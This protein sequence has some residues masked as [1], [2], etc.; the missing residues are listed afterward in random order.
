MADTS[1]YW[2]IAHPDYQSGDDLLCRSQLAQEGRAPEWAWDE[3]DQ[4]FDGDVVCLFPDTA[5]GR[6]DADWLWSERP[7]YAL[8]RI[9]LPSDIRTIQVEEGYPAVPGCICGETVTVVRAG[10]VEGL[11]LG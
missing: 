8:L 6:T 2:H 4:G 3:A 9:D 11:I 7:N 5:G 10:Y 1:T